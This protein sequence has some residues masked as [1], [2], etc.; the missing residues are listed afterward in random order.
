MRKKGLLCSFVVPTHAELFV[1]YGAFCAN[2]GQTIREAIQK[3]QH[4]LELQ[5][6]CVK[7]SKFHTDAI[8]KYQ[9]PTREAHQ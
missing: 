4:A 7:C 3:L 2:V 1:A 6:G 8:R 5:S 9:T